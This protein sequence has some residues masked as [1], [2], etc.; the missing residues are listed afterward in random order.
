MLHPPESSAART[1]NGIA[2][3][4]LCSSAGGACL[5]SFLPTQF[6]ALE[7]FVD[8]SDPDIALPNLIHML[9]TVLNWFLFVAHSVLSPHGILI[10]H[11]CPPPPFRPNAHAKPVDPT[12]FNWHAWCTTWAR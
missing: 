11:D 9:Q 6:R 8:R 7:A 2:H 12:G 10:T 4:L 1:E 5:R 3:W